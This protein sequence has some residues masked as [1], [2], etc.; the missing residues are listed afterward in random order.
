MAGSV[1]LEFTMDMLVAMF[2][3]QITL[4]HEEFCSRQPFYLTCN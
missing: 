2:S 4:I 1:N 3:F